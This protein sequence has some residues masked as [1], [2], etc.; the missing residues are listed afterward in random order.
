MSSEYECS[1][2]KLVTISFILLLCECSLV[3]VEF[4]MRLYPIDSVSLEFCAFDGQGMNHSL[5]S[6]FPF[7]RIKFDETTVPEKPAQRG[8]S[9]Q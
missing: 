6:Q 4:C 1:L 2:F 7:K 8:V 5:D 3:C 9:L